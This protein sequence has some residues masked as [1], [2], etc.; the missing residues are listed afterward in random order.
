MISTSVQ[1]QDF[2][3]AKEYD[4]LTANHGA[5]AVMTFVGKVR[6]IN[7]GDSVTGLYLQHYPGMTEKILN[8]VCEQAKKNW[9][10][11][12]VRVVHRVGELA[13]G[14]QIVFVGVSSEHRHS[15][16]AAGEFIM[17]CLKT[18]VPFWKKERTHTGSRWLESR[19]SDEAA[20]QRWPI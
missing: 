14:E 3:V 4:A 12:Q 5:G 8:E 11:L 9:P 10:L 20:A 2:C 17:D 13:M 1:Y 7:L 6:D 15:A 19:A 16:F 18:R